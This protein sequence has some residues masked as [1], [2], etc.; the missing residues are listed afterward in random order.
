[1]KILIVDDEPIAQARLQRLLSTLG[2][3]N[4]CIASNAEKAIELCEVF[5]FDL[6]F[7]DISM[8]EMNGI[9]LGFALRTHYP[10]MGIIY[11]TAYH[12]HALEAFDIGALH[13]L[14]KPYTAEQ[15]EIA[16]QRHPSIIEPKELRIIVKTGDTHQLLKPEDIYYVKADLSEVVIR[17]SDGFSYYP[18]KISEL[19]PLLEPYGLM[20]VHRSY[21][22][23]LNRIKE[24]ET[25]DQSR[26]RF[27]FLGIKEYVESSK[28]GA[29][30]FRM[31]FK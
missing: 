30:Q 11:Q 28:E 10:N 27:T 8:P 15:L 9:E 25:I 14:L 31:R 24:M 2:Y 1:M 19:E 20:K 29:K 7:L 22:I 3:E 16:I 5:L 13:Y 17:T 6:T 18:K 4:V 12:N 26:I 21:I 23:N